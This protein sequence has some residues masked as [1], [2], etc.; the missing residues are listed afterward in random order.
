MSYLQFR[1]FYQISNT[2]NVQYHYIADISLKVMVIVPIKSEVC[3]V[4]QKL[5]KTYLLTELLPA[6][7]QIF[8]TLYEML[9]KLVKSSDF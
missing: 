1:S 8:T 7:V 5:N 9:L 4:V 6:C 2:I 3:R